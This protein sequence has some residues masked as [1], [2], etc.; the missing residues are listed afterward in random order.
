MPGHWIRHWLLLCCLLGSLPLP[1]ADIILGSAE[2]SPAIRAFSA[3][4]AQRRPQDRVQFQ[5][6]G[7]LPSPA[8]IPADTRLILL[9]PQALDWRLGAAQGPPT[10]VLRV[11]QVH[12]RKRLG[13]SRPADLTLLWSEP[14]PARQLRLARVLLPQARRIGVLYDGHS[15]FLLDELRQAAAPLGLEIVG[16]AWPDS[17]DNRPV[18]ALLRRSDLLL[19]VDDADLYNPRTA[20][21]LLL[22]SY[23]Q[24]RALIGPGAAFVRAGSLASSYSDQADW[25]ASLDQLLDQPPAHWPSSAYPT[26]F[27]VLGNR[28]VARA[29]AIELV[30]D[31]SLARQVA[32]GETP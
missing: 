15:E 32:E 21:N 25:L 5:P 10:L 20:K 19:G 26:H 7:Q 24:Q 18:L 17:R 28:Q 9:G 22:T 6:L 4:L 3:A 8:D 31:A 30:D 2:D 29:L 14:A 11:S 23:A 1:A 12:A 27:K 16:Q 13:A